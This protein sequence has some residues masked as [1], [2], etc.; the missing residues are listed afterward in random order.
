MAPKSGFIPNGIVQGLFLKNPQPKKC[1][2]GSPREIQSIIEIFKT[3]RPPMTA[4]AK[5]PIRIG[6]RVRIIEGRNMGY[7]I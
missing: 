2:V 6:I 4:K 1:W 7:K 3:L 5:L